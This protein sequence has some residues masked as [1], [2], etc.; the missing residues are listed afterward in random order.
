MS[1]DLAQ[2]PKLCG[3]LFSDFDHEVLTAAR[4]IRA[5]FISNDW[6]WEQLLGNGSA[7]A[8]T[9]EQMQK[10]YEAG[11]QA[12]Y[13]RGF[14][15]GQTVGPTAK[16]SSYLGTDADWA[17]SVLEAA[18]KA[19]S[20]GRLSDYESE[21]TRDNLARIEQYGR[22]TRITDKQKNF[23]RRMETDLKYHGY[24]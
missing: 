24:L 7:S 4:M 3:R 15:D 10:I 11:E 5:K 14:A 21:F 12:G 9:Q 22:L 18:T 17:K 6:S 23:I 1:D 20:D 13:E 19:R 8:L 16:P 2:L